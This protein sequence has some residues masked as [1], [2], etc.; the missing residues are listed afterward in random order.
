MK[1]S[2]LL[3]SALIAASAAMAQNEQLYLFRN[4]KNFSFHPLNEVE[5]ITYSGTPGAYTKMSVTTADGVNSYDLST[6]DSCVVRTTALPDI[7]VQLHDPYA[8]LTDLIK[9]NGKSFIYE[10]IWRLGK[11]PR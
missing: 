2:I 6:I 11:I 8:E 10:A 5:S 4:D 9:A 1:K 7:H 3:A